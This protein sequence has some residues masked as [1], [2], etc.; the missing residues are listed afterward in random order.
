ML[1]HEPPSWRGGPNGRAVGSVPMTA[2]LVQDALQAGSLGLLL[3]VLALVL[4]WRRRMDHAWRTVVQDHK[5]D[6]PR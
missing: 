5:L 4:L 6:A 3:S 1:R 2:S